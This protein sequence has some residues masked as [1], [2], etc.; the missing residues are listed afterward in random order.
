MTNR[1]SPAPT[2]ALREAG[3][4]TRGALIEAAARLFLRAGF[5]EVSVAEVAHAVDT[6]PNQVTHH[7]GGKDMLFVEAACHAMLRAAKQAERVTRET[8]SIEAHTRRL[9]AQMLGQG[10]P[11]VMLFAEAMLMARRRP[12][13]A[14]VVRATLDKLHQAG[15]AAMVET[16]RRTGWKTRVDAATIT[17]SFWAAVFGLVM[18]KA[19]A[20]G[21][22]DYGSA[23][24]VALVMM[25]LD[26]HFEPTT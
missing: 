7:F 24:A 1:P 22:F 8:P 11:A 10:A 13:L 17:R 4:Q 16:L 9:I 19:C 14:S 3:S 5:D 20:G 18:E 25:N 26:R 6:F 2:R 12:A 23:E 15:E 21:D